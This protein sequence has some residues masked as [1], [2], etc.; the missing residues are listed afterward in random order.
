MNHRLTFHI[1][2]LLG[3]LILASSTARSQNTFLQRG[4]AA[5]FDSLDTRIDN[6]QKQISRLKLTRDVSYYNLQRELDLTLF[7][8]AYEEYVVDD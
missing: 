5:Y 7:V 1:I 3:V 6:L 8:Q 4:S 2:L